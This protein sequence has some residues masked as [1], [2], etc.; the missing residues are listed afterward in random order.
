MDGNFQITG[1]NN[2]L[3]K[4]S[5]TKNPSLDYSMAVKKEK[6]ENFI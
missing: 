2:V 3:A 6:V 4:I 5:R 1:N